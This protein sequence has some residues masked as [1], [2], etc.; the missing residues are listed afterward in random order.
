MKHGIMSVRIRTMESR[1]AF[2]IGLI[3]VGV[4]GIQ[5]GLYEWYRGIIPLVTIYIMLGI[6]AWLS[7]TGVDR[8]RKIEDQ[9]I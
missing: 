4:L 8:Y 3:V 7:W 6:G 5:I 1:Q 9:E 2:A